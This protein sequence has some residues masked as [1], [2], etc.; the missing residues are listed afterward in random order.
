MHSSWPDTPSTERAKR[1]L[2]LT[3]P[4]RVRVEALHY[5]VSD[6]EGDD[7]PVPCIKLRGLWL[8]KAG[9]DVGARLKLELIPGGIQLTVEPEADP[10]LPKVRQMGR[11]QKARLERQRQE[12]TLG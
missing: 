6:G 1:K 2:H 7:I 11:L 10:N 12:S 9:V 5:P 3:Q 4:A 8:R